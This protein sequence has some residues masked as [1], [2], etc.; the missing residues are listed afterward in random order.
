MVYGKSID[1]RIMVFGLRVWVLGL[2]FW[3][4]RGSR[5]QDMGFTV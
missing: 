4:D 3:V 1:I 5:V 2:G